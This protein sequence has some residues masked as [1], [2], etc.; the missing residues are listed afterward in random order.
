MQKKISR[1]IAGILFACMVAGSIP[2]QAV[3]GDDNAA[4]YAQE[5]GHE[6]SGSEGNT[7]VCN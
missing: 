1:F 4:G 5:S 6:Q 2:A 3:Y 7:D